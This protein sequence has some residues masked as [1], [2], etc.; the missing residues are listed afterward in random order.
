MAEKAV[1]R[2][3]V[4]V[5]V[6][7]ADEGLA[8]QDAKVAGMCD[9][10]GRALVI[11]LQQARPHRRQAA[12]EA[13]RG[14]EAAAAVRAVGARGVRL[15][16]RPARACSASSTRCRRPTRP[17]RA[18]SR[19]ARSTA[20]SRASSSATRRRCIAATP[21]SSISSSS[22]R[23]KPPTFLLSVNH[24]EGVHFSYRR[25]LANQ[26]REEFDLW[27]T[28]VR[29]VS[30]A[31]GQKPR[32]KRQ[33]DAAVALLELAPGRAPRPISGRCRDCRRLAARYKSS[34]R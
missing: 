21:S 26:L 29:I 2:C 7:D 20:G 8:E 31:R 27:G 19:R 11:L 28:P 13:A 32:T 33:S 25:Y 16:A 23:R 12:E 22:R 9:E 24:P 3:D 1:G 14:P 10:A 6:V 15:G 18:A 34:P 30:K 4:C 5:L 17:T